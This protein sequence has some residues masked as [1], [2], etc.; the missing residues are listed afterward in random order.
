MASS[1]AR[2]LRAENKS[3]K[4][5][6]TNGEAVGQ[7]TKHLAAH[8]IHAASDIETEHVEDFIATLVSTRSPGTANN[9]FRALQQLFKWLLAEG[10]IESNPMATMRPPMVPEQPVPVPD[11]ADIK[12]LLKTCGSK[13]FDDRR[14]EAIIRLFADTGIRRGELVGLTVDAVSLDDQVIS[15]LGKGRRRRDI[16]FSTRTAKALDRYEIERSRHKCAHL[17]HFWL[18]KSGRLGE[19]GVRSMLDRRCD[20]AGIGHLHPHQFRHAFAHP[21]SSRT[22]RWSWCS[23]SVHPAISK[24]RSRPAPTP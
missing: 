13:S 8:G 16:P 5:I 20:L 18:G 15:V 9:R 11:V 2:H 19:S 14:D 21:S 24:S 7:L 1:F 23:P 12:A 3:D 4:T 17:P 22:C 10:H 6:A